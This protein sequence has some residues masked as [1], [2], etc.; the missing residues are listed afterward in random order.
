MRISPT[1]F[2][3]SSTAGLRKYIPGARVV[4]VKERAT[5]ARKAE[6]KTDNGAGQ[7][8]SAPETPEERKTGSAA[9]VSLLEE[10]SWVGELVEKGK[11]IGRPKD[12]DLLETS[13]VYFKMVARLIEERNKW[14]NELEAG[15]ELAPSIPKG[16]LPPLRV[17]VPVCGLEYV[18]SVY[19][20]D[21]C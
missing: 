11:K 7:Q 17:I 3:R 21:T 9:P 20:Q 14:L 13:K 18:V 1:S 15:L 4:R 6:R 16:P 12:T 2:T 5:S 19:I 8:D 10:L